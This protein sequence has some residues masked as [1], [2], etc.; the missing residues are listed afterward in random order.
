MYRTIH[1]HEALVM[2]NAC[3]IDVRS[4]LEFAEGSIPGAINVP[5]FDNDERV[6]IGTIYKQI[7]VEKAKARGMEIASAKLPFLIEQIKTLAG[8]RNVIVYCWRGGMRSRSIATILQLMDIPVYQ[9][10]AGYKAYRQSVLQR[11][12]NYNVESRFVVLHGLTGVGKTELLT[13]LADRGLSIIDLEG[14]ANHRGSVFGHIGKG[15]AVSAK[16][17][18]AML[19]EALDRYQQERYV[20]VESESKRIGNVY[21]PDCVMNAMHQGIH[22]LVSATMQTRVNRLL[23]E[24]MHKEAES[25]ADAEIIRSLDTLRNR[26]GKASV[27]KLKELFQ[28]KNYHAFV[29]I[30]LLNYYDPLYRYSDEDANTFDLYVSSENIS[31]AADQILDFLNGGGELSS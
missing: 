10:V 5:I 23:D 30:L 28:Q 22:I 12:Q 8:K 3:L 24:Y 14:L 2:P 18:D 25:C 21:L 20:F 4:P 15:H 27:A 17:F 1:L 26:L 6:E 11:L 31:E 7:G 9:L 13:V 16:N 19:L 29:E